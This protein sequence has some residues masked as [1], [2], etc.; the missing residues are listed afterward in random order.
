M[1][2]GSE[3][4]G[5]IQVGTTNDGN[6]IRRVAHRQDQ[7]PP[8]PSLSGA[9]PMMWNDISKSSNS[10]RNPEIKQSNDTKGK[11]KENEKKS[12]EIGQVLTTASHR[13]ERN[14]GN[15]DPETE[16]QHVP[17]VLRPPSPAASTKSKRTY[18]RLIGSE[19]PL[20]VMEPTDSSPH[21]SLTV[22]VWEVLSSRSYP[23]EKIPSIGQTSKYYCKPSPLQKASF[24]NAIVKAVRLSD[25]TKLGSLLSA[26]LS[27][28]P[29]NTFGE[30]ILD[31]ICKRGHEEMFQ[32]VMNCGGSIQTADSFGRTPLHYA[33]W[34]P[35]PCFSIVEYIL[36][37]DTD[38]IRVVDKLGKTP[39]EYA[40]TKKINEW[41]SF[42]VKN[43]DKFWPIDIRMKVVTDT[44]N[45]KNGDTL[46]DPPNSL[47]EETATQV[48]S[49]SIQPEE[50][51]SFSEH[52]IS[53][54]LTSS[55]S[56][57]FRFS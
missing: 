4:K 8:H 1:K 41:I 11:E 34:C 22:K 3:E 42:F 57:K 23:T 52:D 9:I 27:R 33:L 32:T 48:S 13:P 36:T 2:R 15:A 56:S 20:Q 40:S 50:V 31:T 44:C 46:P 35:Q 30:S 26:G 53:S 12:A 45:I 51:S 29:C 55:S 25:A 14:L 19:I 10:H 18:P 5:Y 21:S 37:K 38:M 49:G 28:N 6:K 16:N 7:H 39:L 43:Q 54:V 47:S 24:G 17:H